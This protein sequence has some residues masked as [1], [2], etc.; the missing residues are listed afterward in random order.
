MSHSLSVRRSKNRDV[1]TLQPWAVFAC[2]ALAVSSC[3][4]ASPDPLGAKAA[5]ILQQRCL[6][7]HSDK[8]AM[9]DLRLTGRNEALHGGKRGP[10]IKPGQSGE[11]LLFQAVSHSGKLKMPPGAK[12]PD[13]EIE[14]LRMDR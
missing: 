12:L 13:D 4:A 1:L 7:C 5:A 2:A 9:S 3:A 10:A 6:A 8:T 11:S 14:T